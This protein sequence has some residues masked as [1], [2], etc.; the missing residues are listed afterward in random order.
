VIRLNVRLDHGDDL[1]ALRFRGGDI[2]LDQVHVGID[3]GELPGRLAAEQIG[4]AGGF[5]VQELAEV[6]W[7]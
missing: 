5:V 3:D 1:R 6:H 2:V 4:G 7:A